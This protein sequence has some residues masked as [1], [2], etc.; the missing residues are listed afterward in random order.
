MYRV[1]VINDQEEIVIHSENNNSLKLVEDSYAFGINVINSFQFSLRISN[2]GIGKI[3]PRKSKITIYNTLLKRNEFDGYVVS[4]GSSMSNDG[5]FLYN[6]TCLDEMGYLKEIKQRHGEYH[7]MTPKQFLQI[8]L[9]TYN[10]QADIDKNFKLGNVNVTNSTDNVYR[11]LDPTKNTF[12]TIME[13]LVEPLGGELRVRKENGVRYLDWLTEVGEKKETIIKIAHNLIDS[14]ELI[15]ST[16]TPSRI[17]PLGARIESDDLEKTDASEARI[18]IADVNGGKDYLENKSIK[19]VLNGVKEETVVF[20]DVHDQNLLLKKGLDE[21]EKLRF[22]RSTELNALDLYLINKSS[23]SFEVGNYYKVS[24]PVVENDYLRIIEKRGSITKPWLSNLIIGDKQLKGSAYQ[25]SLNKTNQLLEN[26]KN[27]L[28]N[29]S[30]K[31]GSISKNQQLTDKVIE[32]QQ[33]QIEDALK[34]IK[35]LEDANKPPDPTKQKGSDISEYNAS[36]DWAK[37]KSTG[38]TF[39]MIKGGYGKESSQINP[40]FAAQVQGAVGQNIKIGMYWF[41]YATN[42]QEAIQEANL[43]CDLADKYRTNISYPISFDW[44]NDSMKYANKLG[45]YPDKQLI[46]D[47]AVAFCNRVEERGYKPMNYSN[48]DY[49]NKYFDDRVK[50]F[51]WWLARPGVAKPDVPCTIWQSE[52]DVD[53]T[54]HGINGNADFDI[55]FKNY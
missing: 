49:Y 38:H 42:V 41:S 47:M 6:Y 29:Q 32:E 26:Y 51:D 54:S 3:F 21:L 2:D 39:V 13:K 55:S 19:D 7:N 43:C 15:D 4:I 20:D 9:N 12:E 45:I 1:I 28:E 44:E 53:G 5:M 46:S 18:T 23:N 10:S 37:F 30:K 17:I 36:I 22:S 27:N 40:R 11:Y 25:A 16:D 34:R 24:S 33:K 35:E 50:K 14:N 31:I 52:L 8:I 48:L